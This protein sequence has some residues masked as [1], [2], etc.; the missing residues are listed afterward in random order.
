MITSCYYC[1]NELIP[2]GSGWVNAT[3][4]T[5]CCSARPDFGSPHVP[6]RPCSCPE[7]VR[8]SVENP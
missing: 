6:D 3:D 4:G 5:L 2:T 7:C 8:L 1:D